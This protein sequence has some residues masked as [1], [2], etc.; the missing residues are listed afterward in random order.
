MDHA[1]GEPVFDAV[2]YPHRSLSPRG[3]RYLLFALAG[4]LTLVGLFFAAQG[5]SPVLPFF[6]CEVLLF[7]WAF[8]AN[9]RDGRRF[10]HLRLT[11]DA[12]TVAQVRPAGG[13]RRGRAAAERRREHRFAPPHWLAV[14]L[15]PRPGGDNELRLASHGHSLTIGGFLTSED[16]DALAGALRDA[17]ARLRGTHRQ[18]DR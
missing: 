15:E 18:K 10:E 7:W 17:L 4:M 6:G 11:S 12:L 9:A 8:R 2:L 13:M 1:P 14:E 16:R 3:V 5:A